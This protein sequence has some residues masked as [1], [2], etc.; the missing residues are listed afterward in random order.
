MS[1]LQVP[2]HASND[3]VVASDPIIGYIVIEAVINRNEGKTKG[4]RKQ[5]TH[6]GSK[7]CAIAV[8]T[9]QDVVKLMQDSGSDPETGLACT[10][11]RR[12]PL[13]ATKSP[14]LTFGH[15]WVHKLGAKT[16]CSR[17]WPPHPPRC[18]FQ[19]NTSAYPREKKTYVPI[20]I[21]NTTEHMV[22][23]D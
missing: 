11:W 15:M 18:E 2:M 5:L 22:Y 7:A 14:T 8:N 6:K 13:P 3:R 10:G 1:D 12:V 17:H 23:L 21:T 9:A 16:C 4:E 19:L 20:P